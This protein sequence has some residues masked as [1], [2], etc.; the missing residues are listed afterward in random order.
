MISSQ[1]AFLLVLN[2]LASPLIL[3]CHLQIKLTTC[4]SLVMFISE[5][6]VV[7]VCSYSA[8]QFTRLNA[9]W[10]ETWILNYSNIF[11]VQNIIRHVTIH[12]GKGG[13][14]S[15]KFLIKKSPKKLAQLRVTATSSSWRQ[16]FKA[17]SHSFWTVLLCPS[18]YSTGTCATGSA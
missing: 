12:W 14:C 1:S 18:R 15:I 17:Y 3:S 2:I 11:N 6:S 8:G 16:M 9:I 4:L 5:T 7:F 10:Y 13:I